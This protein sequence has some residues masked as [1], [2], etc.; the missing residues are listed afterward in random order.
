MAF[1]LPTIITQAGFEDDPVLSNL[2]ASPVWF[3]AAIV[4]IV[5][6]YYSDRHGR[7]DLYIIIP[8]AVGCVGFAL[9]GVGNY[10]DNFGLQYFAMFIA[11]PA[12]TSLIPITLAWTTDLI[13]GST[14]TSVSHAMV[15]GTHAAAPHPSPP[16]RTCARRRC[17]A[18]SVARC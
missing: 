2:I 3:V 12:T 8:A 18:D 11:C 9:L 7:R 5:I 1:Y 16:P 14:R 17:A 10:L 4:I 6:A 13:R 15:V